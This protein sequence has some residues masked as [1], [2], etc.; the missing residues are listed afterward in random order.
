MGA[1]SFS[2]NTN[3]IAKDGV[4]PVFNSM[5]KGAGRFE[6]RLSRL[7]RKSQGFGSCIQVTMQ[8]FNM[9]VNGFVGFF[10]LSKLKQYA[11]SAT[12]AAEKQLAAEQKLQQVLKNNASIR[13][14]GADE[15]LK[16]SKELFNYASEMQQKGI[17]GDEVIL[18]GMQTLGS[19]GFDEKI[20]KKMMPIIADLAVQQKG[21]NVS[22]Q[23]TEQIA[24]GLGRALAGN[25][26]AL[27]RMN[28]IL[29]KSQK[30][31]LEN[32]SAVQRSEYLYKLLSARVGGLNEEFAKTDRGAKVQFYNNLG[33]RLEDIG[34]RIMPIEGRL[35]RFLNHQT[36]GII[37]AIDKIFNVFNS[38]LNSLMPIFKELNNTIKIFSE[39]ILP[40]II[41]L[42]PLLG[43]IIK[44]ILIPGTIKVIQ[45]FNGLLIVFK[46]IYD[47][48]KIALLPIIPILTAA[49]SGLIVYNAVKFFQELQ[50]QLALLK[51][52][53]GG[54]L[55]IALKNLTL[56]II[57]STKAIIAQNFAFMASPL[58]WIPALIAG[59]VAVV[60]L[61][62]KNWDKITETV[63]NWWNVVKSAL[64]QFWD[65]CKNIFGKIGTFIKEHFIDILLAALGPIGLII[66]GIKNVGNLLSGLNGNS[67]DFNINNSNTLT[68]ELKAGPPLVQNNYTTQGS[69]IGGIIEVKNIIENKNNS[70]IY[71]KINLT[72]PHNL[73]LN[74]LT[75]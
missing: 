36:P 35:Y 39:N 64:S 1:G 24:K 22:I 8:K 49:I 67:K 53:A 42:S 58:F 75:P 23:D 48:L 4:T 55:L 33:D 41:K 57:G 73:T 65:V 51:M 60:I 19:M 71:S 25:V 30:K 20:I 34:N 45:I 9:M 28:I 32:M 63:I 70:D 59:I 56:G 7:T 66:K 13:M 43:N 10:A 18:G 31:Q 3:F 37:K 14:R 44:N 69:K 47:F 38:G 16:V 61:L 52:S 12:S 54:N 46:N 21:Y 29:D 2:V 40:E 74:Y 27:G 11:D 72:N 50:L 26:G 17:L 6:N 62:W 68:Q 5:I 15:Y